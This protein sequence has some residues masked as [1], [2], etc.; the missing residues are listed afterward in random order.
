MTPTWQTADSS[1]QLYLADCLDILPQ[2]EAGSVDAVVTDPPYGIGFA[3]ESH[4]DN[5]ADWFTLMDAVVP[6]TSQQLDIDIR[7]ISS[8]AYHAEYGYLANSAFKTFLDDP[9]LYEATYVRKMMPHKKTAEMDLGVVGHAAI[10]EPHIIEGVCLEIPAKILNEDGHKKGDPWKN[11]K[12]EH[13]DRILL[14]ADEMKLVRGMFDAVYSHPIARRLL[15]SEGPTEASIFWTCV[16]SGLKRR[17]RPDKIV[18]GWGWVNVKTT[19]A[20]VDEASFIRTV[21]HFRYDIGQEFYRDAG[22]RLNGERPL[23]VFVVVEQYP[24]HRV[25][26]YRLGTAWE[27]LARS[28]V[29]EGLLDF[30]RRQE[31]GDWSHESELKV[32]TIE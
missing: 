9:R 28:R 4:D 16:L 8:E 12:K 25:R 23:H 18:D 31:A 29:E 2:M 10:L 20:G 5:E 7:Q 27:D 26:V 21:R 11:F 14:K 6:A 22:E 19:T 30:A 13:T 17:C 15:L 3:Y 32:L 1:I 24:P